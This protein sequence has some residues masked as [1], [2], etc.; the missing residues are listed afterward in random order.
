LGK[1]IRVRVLVRVMWKP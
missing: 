1:E